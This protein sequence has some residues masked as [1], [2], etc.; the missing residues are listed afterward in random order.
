MLK[1]LHLSWATL[2]TTAAAI[3]FGQW[4]TALGLFFA[5]LLTYLGLRER[6][7]LIWLGGWMFFLLSRAT[8]NPSVGG[9]S[10][11][12]VALSHCAFILAL[13][14]FT[15]SALYFTDSKRH[16]PLVAALCLLGAPAAV[17]QALWYPSS[18]LLSF[19]FH[20]S[21]HA[22]AILGALRLI[23]FAG[24]R[25][26][27][28]PWL[29]AITLLLL[30]SNAHLDDGM[31]SAAVELTSAALL[32]VSILLVVLDESRARLQRL[33]VMNAIAADAVGARD[34]G[35]MM[36]TA[37][38]ELCQLCG[39]KY[40]WFQMV[41]GENLV[42]KHHVGL[43]GRVADT[44]MCIPLSASLITPMLSGREAKRIRVRDIEQPLQSDMSYAG[45]RNL[46]IVP[47]VGKSELVGILGFGFS[48][49][50]SFTA[51]HLR[52]LSATANQLGIAGE[53][54][55]MLERVLHTQQQWLST[56]DSIND[57]ILVHDAEPRLLRLN[58][59][60]A[61]R[62]G[63]SVP[64]LTGVLLSSSLPNAQD[65]CPYCS[66]A[67]SSGSEVNDP[68]FGGYSLV[69]TSSY[70]EERG[71]KVGTVHIIC[72]RTE[73][74]AAEERYRL[75][76]ES[77]Q[78]GVF[79][80]TPEGRLLDCNPA[81]ASILGYSGL[82]EMLSIDIGREL[83]VS[84][85]QRASYSAEM[86]KQG[87]LRNYE[88][89]LRRKDGGI[90]TLM[91]N[92]FAIRNEQQEIERYQGFLLDITE[93]KRAEDE[94]KRHN[95]ELNALNAMATIATQTFDL[96]VIL[97]NTR[98]WITELF[99]QECDILLLD[100]E[101]GCLARAETSREDAGLDAMRS[102][103]EVDLAA[104]LS[105]ASAEL[106]TE[107]DLPN[108]PPP[109]RLWVATHG[110]QSFIAVMMYSERK[111]QGLLFITSPNPN[112]FTETDRSLALA[113][114]R[115]LSS[116]VEKVLLYAETARAYDNLRN[117]QQQLLQSEKMS[118]I[119][120]LISGVAHEL[121]NPLTAILGY[122]QLL[123][124]EP[125]SER[126]RDFVSKLYRQ[127]QRTHRVVQNLL[128][129]SRQRKPLQS[130]VDLCR[131]LEDT[132]SLRDFDLKLNNVVVERQYEPAIPYITGDAHQLEQ[133]FLNIINNSVDAIM[134]SAQSGTLSVSIYQ[135]DPFVC[136]EFRDSGPGLKNPSKIFDPFYTTKKI[137]KGTGL[138]LSI[139]YGIIKVHCE[140]GAVFLIKLPITTPEAQF[141]K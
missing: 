126:S 89:A 77:A 52:F 100:L 95:R 71:G 94:M 120:Q 58:P 90:V 36:Q 5:A 50:R 19:C 112:Q 119:G 67:N 41:E 101:T 130:R 60:L 86:A 114:A 106:T 39:A 46:L 6:Y 43:P 132:L 117:T 54:L 131:V 134:D 11:E 83:F 97:Q 140:R 47:V 17:A 28:G 64:E 20:A 61:R 49:R 87:H 24:P 88:V 76:F 45:V 98:R 9:S 7:L 4:G 27:L 113:I 102:L 116:A 34:Y 35:G 138:G 91:E 125:L 32:R 74:R 82:S 135:D 57:Y 92:S 10:P 81:F 118:A 121:N 70:V 141:A 21:Y 72:D 129:F 40:A 22:I 79:V 115:Q 107:Q 127:T 30:R 51:E 69:S 16:L 136:M 85:E 93:K 73:R 13:S 84:A 55:A 111:T 96:D 1:L 104:Y 78:E 103:V 65:G 23:L 108:L 128:S 42:I 80:S 2:L 123:E 15:A 122:A 8:G 62:L 37:I 29:F 18:F 63:R 56:I 75:L 124:A 25:L 44:R 48:T 12:H 133:V 110:Y 33:E 68:C 66:L 31:F 109:A 139:C 59:A 105:R 26:E 14:L 38:V 137:G 53:K 3:P 99:R